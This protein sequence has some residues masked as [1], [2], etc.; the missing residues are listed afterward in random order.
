MSEPNVLPDKTIAPYVEPHCE[1]V[2]LSIL[3]LTST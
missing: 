3:C 2:P 1:G